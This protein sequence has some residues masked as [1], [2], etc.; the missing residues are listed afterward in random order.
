MTKFFISTMGVGLLALA[1]VVLSEAGTKLVI[2][3]T[4]SDWVPI[5]LGM[6][7]F[8]AGGVALGGAPSVSKWV[9]RVRA[10]GGLYRWLGTFL[11]EIQPALEAT[12]GKLQAAALVVM[13]VA[14]AMAAVKYASKDLSFVR[15]GGG[16]LIASLLAGWG[17]ML[18]SF[19]A[20][21]AATLKAGDDR[22]KDHREQKERR[23]NHLLLAEHTTRKVASQVERA[24]SVVNARDIEMLDDEGGELIR[25][26]RTDA[27]LV[28]TPPQMEKIWDNLALLPSKVVDSIRGYTIELEEVQGHIRRST[29][30][31]EQMKEDVG[32][33]MDRDR[34]VTGYR[35]VL[36]HTH[37]ALEELKFCLD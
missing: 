5:I 10:R 31:P 12:L 36:K 9:M 29:P 25:A 16:I 26:S 27:F 22:R 4:G 35:A 23:R 14:A 1:A 3:I 37:E 30:T 32:Y 33:L 19:N 18:A 6:T 21:L 34:V 8:L 24:L 20:Y 11:H 28:E 15:E 13:W 7:M 17:A 2:L